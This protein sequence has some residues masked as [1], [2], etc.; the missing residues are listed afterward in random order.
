MFQPRVFP[1]SDL[2]GEGGPGFPSPTCA[3]SDCSSSSAP[4]PVRAPRSVTQ[5]RRGAPSS[6]QG[7]GCHTCQPSALPSPDEPLLAL[8]GS[9]EP[10]RL[11]QGRPVPLGLE[12][13]S[14]NLLVKRLTRRTATVKGSGIASRDR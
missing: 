12:L 4:T 11:W 1:D 2:P 8:V 10:G 6:H 7:P 9:L 5:E 3:A 14:A 13:A